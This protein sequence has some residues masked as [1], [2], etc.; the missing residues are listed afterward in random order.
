MEHSET[1]SGELQI[2][3]LMPHFGGACKRALSWECGLNGHLEYLLP[4]QAPIQVSFR[5]ALNG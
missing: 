1:N 2:K 5:E 4:L 3:E